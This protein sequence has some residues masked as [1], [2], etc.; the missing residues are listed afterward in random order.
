MRLL[1]L[2]LL[3]A[4]AGS[5]Y[6]SEQSA[7]DRCVNA[8]RIVMAMEIGGALWGVEDARR[9]AEGICAMAE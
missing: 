1:P 8:R 7:E 5:P 3:A 9:E 2:L 6:P 4:C